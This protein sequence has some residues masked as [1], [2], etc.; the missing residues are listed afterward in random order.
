MSIDDIRGRLLTNH[1]ELTGSPAT[2]AINDVRELLAEVDQLARWKN[3]AMPVM[4]GLQELGRALDIPLGHSI[5]GPD[6]LAAVQKLRDTLDRK[7]RDIEQLRIGIGGVQEDKRRAIANLTKER[8]DA[9]DQNQHDARE[10]ARLREEV[11][12]ARVAAAQAR[13]GQGVTEK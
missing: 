12:R 5:T 6:A 4:D 1:Y 10:I 7:N 9:R 2:A 8:N 3:E 13:L 11:R